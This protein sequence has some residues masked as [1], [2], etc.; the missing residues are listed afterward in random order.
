MKD[1]KE[2]Y[3]KEIK[4]LSLE[5]TYKINQTTTSGYSFCIDF[6]EWVAVNYK[7]ITR[8]GLVSYWLKGSYQNAKYEYTT[9]QVLH[10]Y[11]N[12]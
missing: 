4:K 1:H 9:D 8:E 3:I 12:Q 5:S 11:L 6:I 7:P 10:E 2:R